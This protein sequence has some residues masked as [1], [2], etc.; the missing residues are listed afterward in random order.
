MTRFPAACSGAQVEG[1]T[2]DAIL[3]E[4]DKAQVASDI[5]GRVRLHVKSLKRQDQVAEQITQV[6]GGLPGVNQVMANPLTGSILVMYDKAAHGSLDS[7]M[8][9]VKSAKA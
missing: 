2:V 8:Q 5:P 3:S 9:A 1:I 6:L 4:M 7:L